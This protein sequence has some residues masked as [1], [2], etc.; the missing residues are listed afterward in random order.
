M[1]KVC[2]GLVSILL[3]ITVAI[4]V[5]CSTGYTT[6]KKRF[7]GITIRIAT[8]SSNWADDYKTMVP[9]FCKETGA[10][11]EFDDISFGVMYEKLKTAFIGGVAKYDMIWHDGMWVPEFAKRGWVRNLEPFLK[12]PNL[13]PE[14]FNWPDD[15]Y[16]LS[17][18]GTFLPGN[19]WNLPVGTWALTLGCGWRPL[20]YR[21]DL[22]EEAG[23]VDPFGDA[24]PP[25]TMDELLE[26]A[27]KLNNPLKGIY[28]F[29]MPAKRPRICFDWS[30]YLWT[31]G[32]EFFDRNFK[33]VFNSPAGV[34]ALE[35]YIELGKVAPPG[36][37][38]YHITECWTAFMRGKAALAWTWQDLAA[39]AREQSKIIGKFKC[40]YPPVYAGERHPLIGGI[41]ADIP[42][43]ARNAEAAFALLTWLE[44]PEND[45]KHA[46]GS[47][48]SPRRST[49]NNPE[50]EKKYLS[51]RGNLEA[52]CQDTGKGVPLIPEWATVD[53][54]IAEELS[55]AFIGQKTPKE[56][57]D[58]AARKV[59]SFM[60][61]AGYY[62]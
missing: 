7:A 16:G 57:L 59:E 43:Q 54:I 19:R 46:L 47:G 39:V 51:A 5:F 34:K 38:A 48:N 28:G 61:E 8:Q 12:D 60:R 18:S 35:T 4:G 58:D 20:Y 44:S 26:Y 24:K 14:D 11:V 37:G 1:I 22:C 13:T 30:Q 62:K 45:I 31:Y 40:A 3:A 25:D 9:R 53:Q 15:F 17:W 50:V 55:K 32:G 42:T 52:I 41:V 49:W 10:K 2:R 56:A 23:L 36:V 27:K 29:V 6:N 21:A 33:P